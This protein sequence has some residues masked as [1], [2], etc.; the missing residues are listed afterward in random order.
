MHAVVVNVNIAAGQFE[1]A[2]KSLHEEVVP[3]VSK[4]PG[5]VKA[6]WSVGA[7]AKQGLSFL[8]FRTQQD[9]E[10]AANMVRNAQPPHGVTFAGAEV[11]EVIAEA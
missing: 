7:D 5:L 1:A 11:R 8:V 3:R 6:Y 10:N 2:R 4:A 9:A